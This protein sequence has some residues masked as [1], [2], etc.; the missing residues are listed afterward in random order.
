MTALNSIMLIGWSKDSIMLIGWS[1]ALTFE[2][3]RSTQSD[4]SRR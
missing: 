3:L 2:V 4:K 1:K